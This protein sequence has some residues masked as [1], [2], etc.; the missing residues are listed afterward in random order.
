MD[1]TQ[2]AAAKDRNDADI[3]KIHELLAVASRYLA[4]ASAP[5]AAGAVPAVGFKLNVPP[6]SLFAGAP[7]A[8]LPVDV[9]H[10]KD[11]PP[12]FSKTG[13]HAAKVLSTGAAQVA[14][15]TPVVAAAAPLIADKA[16][17]LRDAQA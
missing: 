5:L 14:Y 9:P 12:P 4:E 11:D 6:V 15:A 1:E 10:G 16:G 8:V 13:I 17:T 2:R 3:A 7:D